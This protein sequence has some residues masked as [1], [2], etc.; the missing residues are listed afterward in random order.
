MANSK[1]SVFRVLLFLVGLGI[2]ALAFFLTGNSD[3]G[4]TSADIFMWVSIVVIYLVVFCP[5]FFSS[6]GKKFSNKI[7]S[8]ALVWLSVFLYAGVSIAVILILKFVPFFSLNAAIIVQAVIFFIFLINIYFAYFANAHAARVTTDTENLV[9]ALNDLKAGAAALVI[10]TAS[11]PDGKGDL[12][13]R[14][15]KA[16]EDIRYIS[17]VSGGGAAEL[18]QKLIDKIGVIGECWDTL[19]SGGDTPALSGEIG[20]LETL[21]KERKLLR[22]G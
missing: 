1:L 5:F 2:I 10:K 19:L 21:I 17:P 20:S 8:L 22:N 6:L 9:R 18:E 7:P 4:R 3:E 13:N 15:K 11:C 16:A 12:Q 14:I